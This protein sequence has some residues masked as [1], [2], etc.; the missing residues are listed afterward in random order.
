MKWALLMICGALLAVGCTTT[1][2]AG[3][4]CNEATCEGCC[5][6]DAK[7]HL[8]TSDSACGIAGAACVDCA[9]R[10]QVCSPQGCMGGAG[11]GSA[12]NGGGTASTGGGTGSTAGRRRVF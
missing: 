3:N 8:G 5:D 12:A 2:D 9:S 1:L 7:C 6:A 4:G 11:G 10:S